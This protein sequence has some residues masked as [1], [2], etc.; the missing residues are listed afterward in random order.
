VIVSSNRPWACAVSL[1]L[2]WPWGAARA[3]PAADPGVQAAI[4][5]R[6][7][8]SGDCER[9]DR[10]R[11][12]IA[13]DLGERAPSTAT[14]LDVDAATDGDRWRARLRLSGATA[15]ERS[16]TAPDCDALAD[17]AALV[18]VVALDPFAIA[19]RVAARTRVEAP[20]PAP[21]PG[22]TPVPEPAPLPAVPV[23][24]P[25]PTRTAR[26]PVH[27]ALRAEL[28]LSAF[29]LPRIG[30]TVG[31]APLVEG[32]RWRVELPLRWSLP[33]EQFLREGVGGR[34]QLVAAN[35]RGCFVPGRG[36]LGVP[37]C[38]G[39]DAG[40]MIARGRGDAL[41]RSDVAATRWLAATLA[42]AVRWRVH[43][44]FATWL[45]IEGA[46][47]FGR[48]RF[49]V[50]TAGEVHQAAPAALFVAIGGELHFPSSR[51]PARRTQ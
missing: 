15:L 10:L 19:P 23:A 1:G 9:S 16:F 14:R 32:R 50:V 22:A 36:A 29:A 45:A 18:A 46:V 20:A 42:V 51:G 31:L 26:E 11:R 5:V 44:R 39:L 6:W 41:A 30:A 49:H 38:A 28:G 25:K 17:A 34:L 2:A 48:P 43:R 3:Q 13:L 12:R 21:S 7:D 40:A 47:P 37:L 33:R 24:A 4:E 35:P 27:F 8:G